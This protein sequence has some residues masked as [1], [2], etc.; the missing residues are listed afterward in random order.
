MASR[1]P[2]A[3]EEVS[4]LTGVGQC[5]SWVLSLMAGLLLFFPQRTAIMWM[6]C[7]ED[8]ETGQS[9]YRRDGVIA[10]TSDPASPAGV[11]L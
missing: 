11:D 10:L 3:W 4:P 7:L 8:K 6:S 1:S 5:D 2:S 9:T